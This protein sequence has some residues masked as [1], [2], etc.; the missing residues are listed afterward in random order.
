MTLLVHRTLCSILAVCFF[1]S[2]S[3]AQ[4]HPC[5]GEVTIDTTIHFSVS[6]S[7]P[8]YLMHYVVL[9]CDTVDE[10]YI[11]NVHI[12]S[13]QNKAKPQ[14]SSDTLR[15]PY[16][17][18]TFPQVPTFLDFNFDGY[19]DVCLE[20]WN[21]GTYPP[22][23]LMFFRQYNPI[24]K[25]FEPATQLQKLDGSVSIGE[26][27]TIEAYIPMGG[28]DQQWIINSYKYSQGKLLVL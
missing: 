19:S 12:L 10:W 15:A 14:E 17:V 4:K 2:L 3:F 11:A 20:C 24:K 8:E 16:M 6:K 23:Q 28:V 7:G 18:A 13:P 26:N 5:K 21:S 1:A 9:R 25:L 22:S 27:Q